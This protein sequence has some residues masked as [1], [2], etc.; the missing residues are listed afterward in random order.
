MKPITEEN[1]IQRLKLLKLWELLNRKT[2]KEHPITTMQL[3]AELTD[4]GIEV[5]RRTVYSDINALIACG[6][7][8]EKKRHNRDMYYWV[9]KRQFDIPELKIMMDA[10]RSSK[11]IPEDKTEELLD[12]MAELGESSYKKLLRR[13]TV[14]F[15]VV[16]HSN[17]EIY[18]TVDNIEHALLKKKRITFLYFDLDINGERVYRHN[19]KVYNEQP[20]SMLCDDG[21]YYLLCY[22][23]DE[24]CDTNIKTFRLDRMA[25]VNV[26][27]EPITDMAVKTVKSIK[28]Y[29]KQVFK[30]YGGKPCR[31]RLE[32][33]E[34]LIGVIF[35]KFGENTR[36]R[37]EKDKYSASVSV[38]ISPTFWGWLTQFAG[39]M[40]IVS[41]DDV[42]QEYRNWIIM[43]IENK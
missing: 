24:D 4:M 36:I 28:G 39:K 34:S 33:D 43:A 7:M 3:I 13:N 2:D 31:V 23:E 6:Y 16:K 32:F 22:P 9:E 12:K 19:R 38:Q 8:I 5:E 42:R 25:C 10:V 18:K 27:D 1:M 41:P 29:P 40:R 14:R 11:F 17:E 20:L 30:M 37:Q 35:N 15:Q 26:S 21:N